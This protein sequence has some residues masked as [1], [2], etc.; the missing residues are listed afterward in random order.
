MTPLAFLP[1]IVR[2]LVR[3][4]RDIR[5]DTRRRGLRTACTASVLSESRRIKLAQCA[6]QFGDQQR[7]GPSGVVIDRLHIADSSVFVVD[8]E[9]ILHARI[10]FG[11][12]HDVGRGTIMMGSVERISRRGPG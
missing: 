11:S 9:G 12:D 6:H 2:W 4:C 3:D 8:S 7:V 5:R 1:G 10:C